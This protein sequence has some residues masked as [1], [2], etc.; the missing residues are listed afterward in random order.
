VTGSGDELAARLAGLRQRLAGAAAA[1]E[2][3]E[4]EGIWVV[5]IASPAYPAELASR[6]QRSAP[7]VLFGLGRVEALQGTGLGV[8]GS[9]NADA[10][11]LGTAQSAG[12]W[13]AEHGHAVVSGAARGIDQAAMSAALSAGG[14]AIGVPAQ[15]L[16]EVVASPQNRRAILDGALTLATP[17]DPSAPFSVGAAMGRN[18]IVYGFSRTLLVVVST[19]DKGGTWAG[20]VE[21]IRHNWSDVAVWS[22]PGSSPG[23]AKLVELGGRPVDRLDQLEAVPTTPVERSDQLELGF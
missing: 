16:S 21:S 1:V 17:Y 20:A 10:V 15:P 12:L 9:R 23:N 6:L 8:A 4:H 13:A 11:A 14:S 3:W 7:A 22:G 19:V 18:R 2:Q 5:T